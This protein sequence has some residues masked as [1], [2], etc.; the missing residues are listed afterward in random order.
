[1]AW[2]YTEMTSSRRCAMSAPVHATSLMS[3]DATS[4]Y[5]GGRT[6]GDADQFVVGRGEDRMRDT[7]RCPHLRVL[8]EG[9]VDERTDGFRVAQ[10]RDATD[11]LAGVVAYKIGGCP[12]EPADAEAG[13]DLDR[14]DA[15]GARGEHQHRLA[16]RGED[17][18]I[19]DGPDLDAERRRRGDRSGHRVRQNPDL[20]RLAGTVDR[21]HGDQ[22]VLHGP[23]VGMVTHAVYLAVSRRRDLGKFSG[24]HGSGGL[25]DADTDQ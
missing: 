2:P 14:V 22:G 25:G 17:Q 1:M 13:R 5:V 20:A 7:A 11:G 3:A 16:I 10:R 19:G 23:D 12:L 9:G 24:S 4:R 6:R 15:M 21:V 8:L 18:R